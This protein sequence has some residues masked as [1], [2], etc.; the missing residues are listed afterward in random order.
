MHTYI[1]IYIY[2]IIY[3]SGCTF[4]MQPLEE[5]TLRANEIPVPESFKGTRKSYTLSPADFCEKLQIDEQDLG[6]MYVLCFVSM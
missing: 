5:L 4:S 6:S 1:H 2:N 3:I